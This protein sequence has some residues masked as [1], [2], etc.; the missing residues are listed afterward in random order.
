M[1]C[2]LSSNNIFGAISNDNGNKDLNVNGEISSGVPNKDDIA[3]LYRTNSQSRS[4][5]EAL[6][7]YSIP[8]RIVGGLKFY[9]R[10][11]IKDIIA[12]LNSQSML[13]Y[14]IN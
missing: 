12:Y 2:N 6:M 7:S 5:E 13:S 3:I 14:K 4:I 9:D 11:E 8:Y 10:K 1:Y